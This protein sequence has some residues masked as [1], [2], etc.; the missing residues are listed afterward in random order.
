MPRGLCF[1]LTLLGVLTAEASLVDVLTK[2]KTFRSAG[3]DLFSGLARELKT[4]KEDSSSKKAE[5]FNDN[6][7]SVLGVQKGLTGLA[8]DF[9]LNYLG[10][11]SYHDRNGPLVD[12]L[13]QV[14][15][16]LGDGL[17]EDE[18]S[19]LLRQMK[20][21]C[22][23]GKRVFASGGSL[24]EMLSDL[25]ELLESKGIQ[26]ALPHVLGASSQLKEALNYFSG[27]RVANEEL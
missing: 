4:R 1:A 14:S 9:T 12:A 7:L 15:S 17:D 20:K 5:D 6:W 19:S 10:R 18:L 27:P 11:E 22:F 8:K 25:L 2:V 21:V 13:K 3:V 23:E 16:M 26:E 24:H